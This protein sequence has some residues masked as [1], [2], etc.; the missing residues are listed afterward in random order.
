[1]LSEEYLSQ[2]ENKKGLSGF[3]LGVLT[4]Y[5]KK[6]IGKMLVNYS[7]SLKEFDYVHGG[8]YNHLNN[9]LF[10]E[11]FRTIVNEDSNGFYGVSFIEK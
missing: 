4:K 11:K 8:S 9:R 7:L 2:F 1:M 3:A 10:W 5:Q 6:G